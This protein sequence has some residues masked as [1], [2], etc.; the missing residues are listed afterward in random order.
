MTRT[1]SQVGS[2]LVADNRHDRTRAVVRRSFSLLD[3]LLSG[4]WVGRDEIA[5]RDDDY[6]TL[7]SR[8]LGD[9]RMLADDLARLRELEYVISERRPDERHRT[10]HYQAAQRTT[11][12][13]VAYSDTEAAALDLVRSIVSIVYD[14]QDATIASIAEVELPDTVTQLATALQKRVVMH[15]TFRGR[16]R[17]I[18]PYALAIGELG[19][20]FVGGWSGDGVRTFPVDELD[21]VYATSLPFSAAEDGD[22]ELAQQTNALLWNVDDFDTIAEIHFTEDA[23]HETLEDFAG[24]TVRTRHRAELFRRLAVHWPHA[25]LTGPPELRNEF[26]TH[27]QTLAG[28]R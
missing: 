12:I 8:D 19:R 28:G 7:L 23:T 14:L 10:T 9:R 26:I 6:S 3:L 4:R 17:E 18:H 21:N 27:L 1:F 24:T 22:V 2:G 16:V 5:D 11:P 25:T 20:W 15:A 13:E